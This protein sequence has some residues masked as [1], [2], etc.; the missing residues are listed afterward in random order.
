MAL[1][2]Q[3][4]S[5]MHETHLSA[6]QFL[7]RTHL[8]SKDTYTADLGLMAGSHHAYLGPFANHP[9]ENSNVSNDSEIGIE[10]TV[11]DKSS[12]G[13]AISTCR[14]GDSLNHRFQDFDN[15]FPLFG[16]GQ[17]T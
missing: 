7:R 5:G 4:D 11:E 3:F 16:A 6:S 2:H 15:P 10:M 8:G 1:P 12:Q 14:G 17:Q 13:S 9:V